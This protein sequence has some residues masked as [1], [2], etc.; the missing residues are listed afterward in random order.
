MENILFSNSAEPPFLYII[1]NHFLD[2]R[3]EAFYI[4]NDNHS[5]ARHGQK[6]NPSVRRKGQSVMAPA[7]ESAGLDQL[8]KEGISSVYAAGLRTIHGLCV[9]AHE[10]AIGVFS[11]LMYQTRHIKHF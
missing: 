4:F 10:E 7:K 2:P 11:Q 8:D 6:P 5:A 9:H 1:G 3:R